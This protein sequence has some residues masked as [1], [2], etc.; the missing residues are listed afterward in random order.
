[1]NKKFQTITSVLIIL[2]LF[3]L[4]WVFISYYTSPVMVQES[5]KNSNIPTPEIEIPTK[6]ETSISNEISTSNNETVIDSSDKVLENVPISSNEDIKTNVIEIK[7]PNSIISEEVEDKKN[8]STVI[9]SSDPNISNTEKQ[10]ILTEIDE[11]LSELLVVVDKVQ[12]VD[13]TR[14]GIDE[15]VEVQP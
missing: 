7:E 9:I 11:A 15:E 5:S 3:L 1:M 4:I 13:E 10:Q 8:E 12:T 14:L 6:N 2:L